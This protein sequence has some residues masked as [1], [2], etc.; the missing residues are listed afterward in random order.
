MTQAVF[1]F[2]WTWNHLQNLPWAYSLSKPD[3]HCVSSSTNFSIQYVW[4]S[5][6]IF[7]DVLSRRS[8]YCHCRKCPHS[9]NLGQPPWS[10][11]ILTEFRWSTT[12]RFTSLQ[13]VQ[14]QWVCWWFWVFPSQFVRWIHTVNQLEAVDELLWLWLYCLFLILC[15]CWF[16]VLTCSSGIT[17][18]PVYWIA[19]THLSLWLPN[20]L[21]AYSISL[22][23]FMTR[24]QSSHWLSGNKKSSSG[25]EVMTRIIVVVDVRPLVGH[26]K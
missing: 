10:F 5:S 9:S 7:H 24:D 18:K 2:F 8:S 16:L 11:L 23:R 13:S 26:H 15:H 3:M 20:V 4:I 21:L 1:L 12:F 22:I 14:V 6:H 17:W 25:W 19:H